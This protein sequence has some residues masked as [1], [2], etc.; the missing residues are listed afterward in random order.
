MNNKDKEFLLD[1]VKYVNKCYRD[2]YYGMTVR[3]LPLEIDNFASGLEKALV[4]I[5]EN[6][7]KTKKFEGT[8]INC[9]T[10]KKGIEWLSKYNNPFYR[11]GVGTEE[12]DEDTR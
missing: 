11:D 3:G 2:Y 5:V 1:M 10:I 12:L 7:I 6:D 8:I 9:E 4:H